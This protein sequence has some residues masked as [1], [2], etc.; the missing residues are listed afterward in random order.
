MK[1]SNCFHCGLPNPQSP[2]TLE[3]NDETKQFCCLGC[4]SA[5]KTIIDS[6]LS[7][8]YRFHQPDQH[9]VENALTEKIQ[10]TFLIYDREDVQQEFVQSLDD[11]TSE[12]ILIIEGISCSAC[13]WLIEKRLLQLEGVNKASVNA[14]T[15]RLSLNWNSQETPLSSIFQSLFLIGYRASPFSPDHEDIVNQRTAKKFILRL[16]VAGIGMM[17][18]M[19]NAVALY[20]GEITQVH[21]RW[22]WWTSLFLTLPVIFISAWPFFTAA[23]HSLKGKQLSMDVSVSIAILSAFL[24]SVYAT[25]VGHGEVYFESVNMFTFFLVLSRYLE[26][27]ARTLAHAQGNAVR[28]H[29]P[30]TCQLVTENETQ[31]VSTRDLKLG[32]VINLLPGDTC[33]VDGIVTSG[34]SEFDESS[35]TG[36]FRGIKKSKG[37]KV[38]AGTINQYQSIQI[39]MESTTTGSTFNLLQNLM[40]RASAE[41]SRI[42]ELADK[43]S[44]Q[45]IWTTLV[46]SLIIGLVWL[47]VDADRAFWIVISV[48]VVT[49]PCALSLATPTALAQSTLFLKKHGIIVT[50][51]YALER[52]ATLKHIAFDK[53]G[54]LTEGVFSINHSELTQEGVRLKLTLHDA[55]Q[56]AARL[57]NNSEH[58]IATAF[59]DIPVT[60][61]RY[62]LH[63]IE[64]IPSRGIAAKSDL[65]EWFIGSGEKAN[66][67]GTSLSLSLNNSTVA[68]FIVRDQLRQTVEPT[69]LASQKLGIKTHVLTGDNNPLAE[70][71]LRDVNLTGD[72]QFGCLPEDKVEWISNRDE[73][74]IAVVGDGLNDAPLLAKAPL[75]IAVM[76]ATDMT[77]SQADIVLLTNDLQSLVTAVKT[78]RKTQRIIRQNLA[79]ALL[80]NAIALPIASLG[81]VS[82]WQAAIGMSVSSLVVVGNAIRL[83][84]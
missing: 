21:E 9:P 57:E 55:L 59:K 6:G 60:N 37:D 36:E 78:A 7:E 17:Q 77:K 56:I 46:I 33:P 23:W 48:L 82:P 24:A 34:S 43:G 15:H 65:G 62:N 2:L 32:D 63:D 71:E 25:I 27:R 5:A 14:G 1:S 3:I 4:Q 10:T 79:W 8:Y 11:S 13:T 38:S 16:G 69:F 81:W 52:L 47:W 41:K 70:K 40:E 44:R 50:R 84:K 76:N 58:S 72:F 61:N 31:F 45:F 51:G 22:L 53:T 30:Q 12:C 75:S 28:N 54:T 66:Q 20:S 49:C 83:R 64:Q 68:T 80:Y 26:F 29:L 67:L 18:A 73:Q 74:N 35:F 42:A 39:K 19:M